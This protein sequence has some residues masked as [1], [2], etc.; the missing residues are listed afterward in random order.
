MFSKN[1]KMTIINTLYRRHIVLNK[2]RIVS[3]LFG[4][5]EYTFGEIWDVLW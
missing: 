2:Y 3:A 4:M 5:K 1:I